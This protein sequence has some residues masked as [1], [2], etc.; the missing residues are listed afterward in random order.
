MDMMITTLACDA[1][2]GWQYVCIPSVSQCGHGCVRAA[3]S[4]WLEP[5]AAEG[6]ESGGKGMLG[7]GSSAER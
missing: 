1:C 2:E 5:V 7:G 4:L 3:L 6:E